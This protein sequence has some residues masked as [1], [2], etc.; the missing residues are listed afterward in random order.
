M[1]EAVGRLKELSADEAE[2]LLAINR[3]KWLWDK[4]ARERQAL[5]DGEAK[6]LKKGLAKGLKQGLEKGLKQ[7]LEKKQTEIAE[8]LLGMKMPVAD[9]AAATGL[10]VAN[11]ERL[12]TKK[13]RRG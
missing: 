8:R 10:S 4:A 3:E 7:G 9:I 13:P 6:G 2:R 11:I 5:R 1:A 12:A